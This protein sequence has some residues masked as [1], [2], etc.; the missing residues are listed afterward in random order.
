MNQNI[1]PS[2]ATIHSALPTAFFNPDFD[3]K[4]I[5]PADSYLSSLS[6]SGRESMRSRLNQ[7]VR[8]ITGTKIDSQDYRRF[9]FSKLRRFHFEQIM[10][11]MRAMKKEG[12]E[13]QYSSNHLK[14]T[15]MCLRKVAQ[16]AWSL[17]LIEAEDYLKIES[18]KF[19]FGKG[20]QAG[21]ALKPRE[22]RRVVNDSIDSGI[23]GLRDAAMLALFAGVGLRRHELASLQIQNYDRQ[24]R[25]IVYV[26]KRN[27][28]QEK[29]LQDSVVSVLEAWIDDVRG[30][31]P[32]AMFCRIFKNDSIDVSRGLTGNGIYKI[33]RG[34]VEE[35]GLEHASPHDFRRGLATHL[36]KQ[37]SVD[38]VT[39]RDILGHESV[40]TTQ[41]YVRKD[42]S[43]IKQTMNMFTL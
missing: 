35:A 27:K 23:R 33:V 25:K 14:T 39:V 10:N 36:L 18:L 19:D 11:T 31:E 32:G 30:E 12:G 21:R 26:G 34:R 38:L 8:S 37:E 2:I 24:N 40:S 5:N 9:D 16:Q 7:V 20:L 22:S 13:P 6:P 1:L 15:W 17:N 29:F 4:K 43:E 41:V 28:M 42:E 3:L